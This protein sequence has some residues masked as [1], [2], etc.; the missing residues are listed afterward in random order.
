[1]SNFF[2]EASAFCLQQCAHTLVCVTVGRIPHSGTSCAGCN[3][4][5]AVLGDG[6]RRGIVVTA[7]PQHL[8]FANKVSNFICTHCL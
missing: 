6:T 4:G 7:P 1:M 8:D 3:P 5:E 2:D